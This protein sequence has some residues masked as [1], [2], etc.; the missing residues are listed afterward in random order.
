MISLERNISLA[1]YSNYKIGGLSRYFVMAKTAEELREALREAK[2]KKLNVFIL[3]SGTNLII[4]DKGFNGLTIKIAID[5]ITLKGSRVTVGA[6]VLMENLLDFALK[7]GLAGLAWAGG[8]PGTVGGAVRGNA[9]AFKGETKDTIYSARTL[10]TKTLKEKVWSQRASR[11]SY[12]SSIFK[13]RDGEEVVLEAVFSLRKG[14]RKKILAEMNDHIG[15]RKE[16]QPLNYP[17]IGSIFKNVPL[18]NVPKKLHKQFAP[19][20]KT[21]P[22]PVVPTAYLIAEAGLKGKIHGGAM[23]SPKHPN[24]IVNVSGA[25]ARDVKALITLV[26]KEVKKKFGIRIEPEVIQL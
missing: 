16:R 5:Y 10:N 7:N 13:E 25:H 12:R 19:V 21:D 24:F 14:D 11:F 1:K 2:R 15:Y 22:F 23:I 18:K 9:G 26:Q 3:G 4:P 6:G 20:I 8:L 17:N